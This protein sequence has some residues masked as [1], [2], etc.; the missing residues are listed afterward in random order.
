MKSCQNEFAKLPVERF[1]R[2]RRRPQSR[3]AA[4]V[5]TLIL[6]M[7]LSAGALAIV[8]LVSSDT[9]INGFYRNYRGSFYAADSGVNIVVEAIRNGIQ[10][11]ANDALNPPLPLV[12]N[13]LT[14]NPQPATPPN[15]TVSASYSP[16]MANYYVV[17]DPGSWN[18][19]FKLLSVTWQ[20]PSV[21]ES[22]NDGNAC[23]P[24]I[25]GTAPPATCNGQTNDDDFQWVYSYPFTVVVLGQSSGS[26]QEQVTE[27]GVITYRSISGS[28]ASGGPPSFSKWGAFITDFSD[29]QGPLVPGTMTGPFFTDGQ[30]NFGNFSNPGY[31]FTDSV[32]QVGSNVSW[33]PNGCVDSPTAPRGFN[34][35]NF[36]AGLQLGAQS[37]TPPT[38]SYNQA[39]AV[40]DGE[41]LPPCTV[42]PCAPDP[43]PST[44]QMSQELKTASGTA[45]STSASTGVFVPYY[46]SGTGPSGQSCPCYGSSTSVTGGDGYAGGFYVQGNASITLSATTGGDGTSNA[47]QTYTITQGSTTTTIVV[48]NAANNGLGITT[49]KSG[50]GTSA[51]TL[52]LQGAPQQLNPNT[53]AQMT[54][55]DPSGSVVSPTLLYVNGQITGLSGTVQNDV[56]I[57]IA[58]SNGN[59]IS[60]TG[61]LT[62]L[63]LPV[64]TSSDTLNTTTNAGVL[65]VY[66]NGNINLYPDSSG[67]LT[68]D[69]SL[70]AIGGSGGNAGFET[71]GKAIGTWTIVGGR[72]EDHAHSVNIS[73]GNTVYDRR[74]A[75]GSFGPPW[76]PTAVPQPG[77]APIP[78]SSPGAAIQRTFWQ[79]SR[80]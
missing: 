35:P 37:V 59:D 21:S 33:W 43:P 24:T 62:Y 75:T 60:I 65:G 22:A 70:A 3:G 58:A 18:G 29:C 16:Y 13:P 28:L 6:L 54:Q 20:T 25:A 55:T 42:T 78:P 61:D 38:D 32:G 46:T 80:P 73:Q 45:Y 10:T 12:T 40:L 67:N 14:G 63:S 72:S 48:D 71:P 7:L 47:T 11:S 31:T 8:L 26:E 66:T 51:T 36:E 44:T 5:V 69:A 34:Q 9:M 64:S 17:G 68:V 30:W 52:T 57:T 50:S 1:A 2:Q 41:G 77:T 74:F 27:Q 39:Q 23:A 15:A 4:L 79:E 76:F 56:G 53:G 49:V 19:Q